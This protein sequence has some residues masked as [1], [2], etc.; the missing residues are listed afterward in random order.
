MTDVVLLLCDYI[1]RVLASMLRGAPLL[2]RGVPRAY[3]Y[4]RADRGTLRS[5]IQ[6]S[7][8][9]HLRKSDNPCPRQPRLRKLDNTQQ[10]LYRM[11]RSP[12]PPPRQSCRWS[13]SCR[14]SPHRK[15]RAPPNLAGPTA[16]GRPP[17][18]SLQASKPH[19]LYY[20]LLHDQY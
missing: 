9:C 3:R 18:P 11:K 13:L 14:R 2:R 7:C 17:P 8:T 4:H 5:A 15:A 6:S 16:V 20:V 19:T 1:T 12:P 10:I